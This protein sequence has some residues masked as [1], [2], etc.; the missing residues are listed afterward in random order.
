MKKEITKIEKTSK[1]FKQHVYIQLLDQQHPYIN[2]KSQALV[3]HDY[4]EK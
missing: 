3:D 1:P 4:C 2:R